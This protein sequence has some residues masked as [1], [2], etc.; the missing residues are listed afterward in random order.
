VK[1]L[2]QA[3]SAA[4]V[5]LCLT[6]GPIWG[7]PNISA[8]AHQCNSLGKQSACQELARIAVEDKDAN[9]RRSAVAVLT[10]QATL[11]TVAIHDT[12]I[13]VRKAAVANLTDQIALTA[14]ALHDTSPD[15]RSSAVV[16]LTDPVTLGKIA[17][18]DDA[19]NVRYD[20]A[21]GIQ[22]VDLLGEIAGSEK[23]KGTEMRTIVA[24]RKLLAE[25]GVLQGPVG[26]SLRA[27]DQSAPYSEGM[28]DV[29]VHGESVIVSIMSR[30]RTVLAHRIWGAYFPDRLPV[31]TTSTANTVN[32]T[33]L[34]MDVCAF[35]NYSPAQIR[36]VLIN[37]VAKDKGGDWYGAMR[38][39]KGDESAVYTTAATALHWAA[40]FGDKDM[41][42]LLLANAADVNAKED[43]GVT[44][45]HET[46]DNYYVELAVNGR[47]EVAEL[48]LAHGADVNAKTNAGYTPL[49]SAVSRSDSDLAELLLAHGAD[50]DAKTN[51]GHTALYIAEHLA[52]RSGDAAMVELLRQHGGH[53]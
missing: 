14:V 50:V 26:I 24:L 11:A 49:H 40:S 1:L 5:V 42:A 20:A 18:E 4:V 29:N 36:Q 13:D 16:K 45:L 7:R 48:L 27:N 12:D 28:N 35:Q 37:I 44:P 19:V 41:A 38:K 34:V 31:G 43:D 52:L 6:A 21:G 17:V 25:S 22:D 15:L 47:E 2:V 32:L 8:L 53:E 46:A 9:A 39:L 33:D 3:A 51:E 23:N 30:E 10:D